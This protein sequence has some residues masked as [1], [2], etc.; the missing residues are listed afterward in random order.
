MDE[1]DEP[2]S[3]SCLIDVSGLDIGELLALDQESPLARALTR[4]RA[5][6]NDSAYSSFN[7]NI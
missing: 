6:A 7:A 5:A 3:D 1:M 2:V 4:V